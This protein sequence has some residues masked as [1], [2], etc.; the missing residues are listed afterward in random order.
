MTIRIVL[1]AALLLAAVTSI[2]AKQ[3][4]F[5]E[6]MY[7]PSA[8]KPEFVEVWNYTMTPLDM[9]KWRF[10]RGIQYTFPDF[11]PENPSAH[12]LK[13][14]ERI[15]V[16]SATPSEVRAA[17]PGI[18]ENVRILGPWTG[19]LDNAGETI[20]LSDKNGRVLC[21][22]DYDDSGRWSPIADGT[23]HSLVLINESKEI[24]DFHNWR[25]SLLSGGSPGRGEDEVTDPAAA[26]RGLRLSE[27]HFDSLGMVDWVEIS[28]PPDVAVDLSGL[29]ISADPEL[30]LS[31]PLAGTLPAGGYVSQATNFATD[32]DGRV[33][34]F[35]S[36]AEG[37]VLDCAP[38]RR[39]PGR[40][41]VQ[42]VE[43]DWRE[44]Y[45]STTDTRDAPNAPTGLNTSIVINEVMFDQPGNFRDG[46]YIELYNRGTEPVNLSGWQLEEAVSFAFPPGTVIEPG[47]YLVVASDVNRLKTMHPGVNAIGNW[48][49]SLSAY[50]EMIRLE[51]ENRNLVDIV[52]YN[53]GGDWPAFTAGDGSSME[54]IHPD[55]DNSRSS[56]WLDS[57]ESTKGQFRQFTVTAPFLQLRTL[58][59]A[60]SYKELHFHLVG[61]SHIEL[62]NIR[63]VP[64]AGGDNLLTNG[65]M[66]STNGN[67]S[68]GWLAQG[69]H[70]QSFMDEDGVLHLISTGHGDNRANRVE[71]DCTGL[72]RNVE[73]T[74]SFEARWQYGNPRLIAQTWDHSIGGSFLVPIPENLGTPGKPN[75]RALAAPAP[76]VDNL[77]HSPAVPKPTDPVVVTARVV[78]AAPLAAVRVWHRAD[79]ANNENP[80]SSLP[81]N[82][83]G[84]NGDAKAGD[85]IYSAT[86]TDHQTNGR[87]VQFYVEA[88]AQNGGKCQLPRGGAEGPG[89]WIVDG[90]TNLPATLRKTRFIVSAYHLAA[91]RTSTGQSARFNWKFPRLSN[92][93]FPCT[94][95]DDEKNIYYG[96][97]IRKTGSPWTRTDDSTLDRAR[98]MLPRDRRFRGRERFAYDND[99]TQGRILHNR[100]TR[101]FCYL[102]GLPANEGEFVYVLK[103]NDSPRLSE[104]M[105]PA[106][107]DFLD[108]IYE[109]GSNGQL[110]RTDD[111]WWFDD[112]WNR[113]YRSADW[114]Y[115]NTDEAIRYHTE[116]MCRSRE[117]DY[118]YAPFIAMVKMLSGNQ[119]TQEEINRVMDPHAMSAMAAIRGYIMDWDSLTLERG[120]N[121]FMYRRRDD[122]LWML[123]QWDSDL[124]FQSD[125][126]NGAVLGSLPRIRN[127]FDKPY[128]RRLFNYYLEELLTK[129]TKDSARMLAW[130]DAEEQA[131][132]AYST[133]RTTYLNWFNRRES[134]IVQEINLA[135]GGGPSGSRTAPFAVTA[136]PPTATTNLIDLTGTAPSA[137]FS[138]D[139]EGVPGTTWEFINQQVWI[140]RNIALQ[141]G[142]NDLTIRG[143]DRDGN[144]LHTTQVSITKLGDSGPVARLALS[145]GSLHVSPGQPIVADG[146][147]SF[148][149]EGGPLTWTWSV[150]P[151]GGA[152]L[153]PSGAASG[154]IVFSR[155][156]V[157]TVTMTV[158]DGA[159]NSASVSREVTVAG[160]QDLARFDTRVLPSWLT[161][162]NVEPVSNYSP[163]SW[164]SLETRPNALTVRLN[165]AAGPRPLTANS[166]AFP[167]LWRN[168]PDAGDWSLETRLD[169]TGREFGSFATGLI[170]EMEED[171]QVVRYALALED[172]TKVVVKRAGA[173]YDDAGPPVPAQS[174]RMSLRITRTGNSLLFRM[175]TGEEWSAV[176][177]ATLPEG[178][179]ARRGGVFL[180][181]QDGLTVEVAFE[182]LL[183][184]D[185]S[186]E[187]PVVAHLRVTEIMYNPAGQGGPEFIEL[188]N[189]G[190]QPLSLA[191]V[192][193][194]QGT[195]FDQ[196]VLENESLAP[197]EYAVVTNDE[198][199]FRATYGP[200]PRILGVWPGG[201]LSNG[202]EDVLI[203]DAAGN[204]VQSFAWSDSPPWPVAADG[205]GPSLEVVSTSGD[206]N[207]PANWRASAEAGGT[208]GRASS[209]ADT[210]GDGQTDAMELLTGTDPADP[211]SFFSLK[212][213]PSGSDGGIVLSWPSAAGRTYQIDSAPSPEGPWTPV[214]TVEG[215]ESAPLSWTVV[216]EAGVSKRFFRVR[217][218]MP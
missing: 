22:L 174:G 199:A 109:D 148:D 105:E 163:D 50:G 176:H 29:K 141:E 60:T 85:G 183:L 1:S 193:F 20:E 57:D 63:L 215:S 2:P 128:I 172:G 129:Y 180:S 114:S 205:G 38:V 48:R 74:L 8:G 27:V 208:P 77:L 31:V 76:Q 186:A 113:D 45:S 69:T 41:S 162:E 218:T 17:Y 78:S 154:N 55:M 204:P 196:M 104:E 35:L 6:V 10:T 9:A 97:G 150:T 116:W 53:A 132:T 133:S 91:S 181:S 64:A 142:V 118:D 25:P 40:P 42:S 70:W 198:A 135:R 95:I 119:F 51:D 207:D 102:L 65:N 16:S 115:K 117:W 157:H 4:G 99:P 206:Y 58:G 161:P 68:T 52:D 62:R 14:K 26:I 86:I 209:G 211:R 111:E 87:I 167:A 147:G 170:L 28:G 3:V 185:P 73:Y 187:N 121:G 197:G 98:W 203:L 151:P 159:G 146:S 149:P 84:V 169:L 140:L 175:R 75:S 139:V 138:L 80:W 5:S 212:A 39:R 81:M 192:T 184:A 44:W 127:Y 59:G 155:G 18:P 126:V 89:L 143:L 19:A 54:L 202:G 46:E 191:G 200:G 83:E 112:S 33:T 88:E 67:S 214:H 66:M 21:V 43:G 23:G 153:P 61:D 144:V 92:H 110:L 90:R 217:V 145:P 12:I 100:I 13:P 56:A 94:F 168:L 134:R 158:A 130:L 79:D 93:Y 177:T 178:A 24:D 32:G 188:T 7:H 194:V 49:G 124:A 216:P 72:T 122:G 36:T 164:Y 156:G 173:E 182:S 106:S 210:D 47:G 179:T 166:P 71:I 107:K 120:K 37:H 103:N 96:A 82:D 15:L 171:G 11:S 30:L 165:S 125:R 137:V 189:T 123:L 201:S 213:D 190:S 160:A 195:P 136:P 131:S 108:R 152:T 101:Y 34:L